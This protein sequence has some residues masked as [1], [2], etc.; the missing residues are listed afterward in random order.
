MRLQL[1][2]RSH[3]CDKCAGYNIEINN[4]YEILSCHAAEKNSLLHLL[5]LLSLKKLI[6]HSNSNKRSFDV[7]SQTHFKLFCEY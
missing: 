5:M 2:G 3:C 7:L 4:N 6:F 1:E